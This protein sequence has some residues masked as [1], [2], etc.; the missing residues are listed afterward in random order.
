MLALAVAMMWSLAASA[1]T[2]AT[3]PATQPAEPPGLTVE[4]LRNSIE[5]LRAAPLADADVQ[6][7]VMESFGRAL[8]LLEEAQKWRDRAATFQ[9]IAASGPQELEQ[10]RAN[11]VRPPESTQP[12]V[13]ADEDADR[14]SRRLSELQ[15]ELKLAR[16]RLRQNEEDLRARPERRKQLT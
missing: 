3:A 15:A 7:S 14:L 12:V 2:P 11:L 13:A 9:S 1:Q 10:L 4:S 16:D 8:L 6:K 5:A